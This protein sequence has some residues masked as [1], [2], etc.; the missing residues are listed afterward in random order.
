MLE[1]VLSWMSAVAWSRTWMPALMLPHPEAPGPFTVKPLRSTLTPAPWMVMMFPPD[2]RVGGA[3][4]IVLP[5]PAPISVRDV[6]I[7]TCSLYVPV[8]TC[9]VSPVEATPMAWP[10]VAHGTLWM[11]QSL[12][13]SL[14]A[15]STYRVAAAHAGRT[16]SG[17][18]A[19]TFPATVSQPGFPGP[20]AQPHQFAVALCNP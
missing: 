15:G 4:M 10:I 5:A 20:A 3:W 14:P 8:A 12:L 19:S 11:L 16:P 6:P 7:E 17:P 2:G 13:T 9:T 1:T 18:D